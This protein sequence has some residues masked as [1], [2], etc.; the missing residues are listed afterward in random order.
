M[1]KKIQR[2]EAKRNYLEQEKASFLKNMM[3]SP[4][5]AKAEI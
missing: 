1:Y 4:Q 3:T 2:L 5:C